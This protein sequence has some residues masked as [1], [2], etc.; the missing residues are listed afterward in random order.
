MARI[1]A[2][3]R[4]PG[5]AL[6]LRLDL[7]NVSFDTLHREVMVENRVVGLSRSELMLLELLLRRAGR[8]V[9][10]R[11]LEEGLYGFE[12]VVGP[13]SLEAHVS[14]LRK[15]LETAGANIQIHTLRGVGYMAGERPA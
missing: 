14:R 4:R 5:G 1:K 2:L 15:K 10:R 13:N 8:V 9:A 12:D 6:G 11:M 7:G 3:L